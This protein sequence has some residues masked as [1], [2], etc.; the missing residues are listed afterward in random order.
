MYA[1]KQNTP[2]YKINKNDATL[3]FLHNFGI[4]SYVLAMTCRMLSKFGKFSIV[5]RPWINNSVYAIT[6]H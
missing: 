5:L 1:F 4:A 6:P 3:K 2:I